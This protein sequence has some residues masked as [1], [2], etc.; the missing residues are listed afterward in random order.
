MAVRSRPE[1]VVPARM[2]SLAFPTTDGEFDFP[3]F[4]ML[5]GYGRRLRLLRRIAY[6]AIGDLSWPPVWD[7]VAHGG[8]TT[9]SDTAP[10]AP[11]PPPVAETRVTELRAPGAPSSRPLATSGAA[12]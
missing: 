12:L 4:G 3:V 11:S 7:P 9:P 10:W 2:R 5:I 8:S 6:I 1:T